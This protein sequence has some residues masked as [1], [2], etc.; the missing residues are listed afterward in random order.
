MNTYTIVR[1][2]HLNH[3]GY[4]FGGAMLRWVDENAWLVA[5][6]DFCGCTLVTVAMDDVQFRKR[7]PSGSILRFEILPDRLG[8]T[9]VSYRVSVYA[10]LPGSLGEEEVF[11]TCVTFVGLDTA[12]N[13][14]PLPR[15]TQFRSREA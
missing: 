13:K 9:S 3:H 14:Q 2:E 10:D 1:P 6:R 15:I 8:R 5:S 4:L 12:G 7:A 11:S